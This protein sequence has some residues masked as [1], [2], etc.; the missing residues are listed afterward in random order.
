M[1]WAMTLLSALM[2]CLLATADGG[3]EPTGT[4]IIDADGFHDSAGHAIARLYL[5]GMNVTQ[6][7]HASLTAS[8]VDHRA[9]FAFQGL[10]A[11]DY[12][13]VVV[14]DQNDNQ[15]IDHNRL[16]FPQEPLGFSN[17]F[18]LS[19]LSGMPTFE[20]LRFHFSPERDAQTVTVT[21]R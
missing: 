15:T 3:S 8:I 1:E 13:V 14:H 20:K 2:L 17:G 12:A 21:V 18:R 5:P 11:G 7:P 6:T 4:L 19:L 9:H 10:P 16:G